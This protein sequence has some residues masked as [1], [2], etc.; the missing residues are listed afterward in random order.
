MKLLFEIGTEELPAGEIDTA[1][2]AIAA[3]FVD[4][5]RAARLGHGEVRTMATPRRL[6]LLVEDIA[7]R[8]EDHEEEVTGPAAKAAFGEDGT[9]TRAAEGF[10]RSRGADVADLY[11]IDTPKGPYAAL[12]IHHVG[13]T[14]ATLLP[15][16]LDGAFGAIPWKRSMRW[17]WGDA[18]FAR[19]I[20]RIVALLDDDVL[21][22]S[23][24]GISAG[25]TTT[26]H[27]FLAPDEVDVPT[28]GAWQALLR[29]RF[30]IADPAE[31]RER[32]ADGLDR[33]AADAGLERIPDDGL[34]EEVVHLVEWP[35]PMLGHFPEVFLELPAEVLV[36]SMRS[37]QRY[38]AMRR[39]DGGLANAFGFVSNM[40]VERPEVIV[41]G[42]LRVL[43]ARL[44]DARFFFRED[45]R[46]T[47]VSRVEDLE[48]VVYIDGL[49]SVA[50]RQQRIE[51]L[52]EKLVPRYPGIEKADAEAARRAASLCK[53]DLVTGMVGEFPDL[54]GTMGRHYA[55][56][57]GENETVAVA[58][59]E[60][61]RPRGAT[62]APPATHA[63]VLVS[64]AEKLDA[65]TGAFALGMQPSGSAD[66]QGLRRA[67][68]GI[69][70]T[71]LHHG[72]PMQLEE[73]VREAWDGLPA[74]DLAPMEETVQAIVR[75]LRGRVRAMLTTDH[76]TDLVD[77]ALAVA[78]DDLPS[79][80]PRIAAIAT[81]RDNADFAPLA[82][83]FK[84]VVNIL[85]RAEE[86]GDL[87]GT[88]LDEA[89]FEVQAEHDL[90]RAL[91]VA[92]DRANAAFAA[93]DHA[94]AAQALIA[95]K[96]PIDAF[97]D[98][99][100]VN[101]EDEALRRNRL[102]LLRMVRTLFLR[103]ADISLI[104]AT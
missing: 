37:H 23:F 87:D 9:P 83:A 34:L 8:A 21:P 41:S 20:H 67:A 17:G 54:Q 74:G 71:L 79:V 96:A 22:V 4:A 62:D 73:V 64:L 58:I 75:F 76:D 38:F 32:I 39:P 59:E 42:N 68:L 27:R 60:H 99:V 50:A 15:A 70:R 92:A 31:R 48:R 103:L 46:R 82:E 26:G 18:T 57:D 10:A 104:Q 101:A 29:D 94:T 78:L 16:I 91:D 45:R 6:A 52:V 51:R 1:R 49:G 14:A 30:V 89:L 33:L 81:L 90:A 13:E 100:L 43:L 80:R 25:R 77:A 69:V 98:A 86:T 36:T 97:F 12:R 65:I 44:E 72:L 5:A 66:P 93:R 19:P 11:T 3:H 53:A 85:L 88:S 24:A 102:A 40:K 95:L 63:G 55:L 28:A 35:E 84:R 61:Y 7:E 56:L 2:E 47:L